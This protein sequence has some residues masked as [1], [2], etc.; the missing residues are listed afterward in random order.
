MSDR[1]V[2]KDRPNPISRSVREVISRKIAHSPLERR[3]PQVVSDNCRQSISL[4]PSQ[5]SFRLNHIRLS[6]DTSLKPQSRQT[7]SFPRLQNPRFRSFDIFKTRLQAKISLFHFPAHL[8]AELV[9]STFGDR[10][11]SIP[12]FHPRV[13]RAAVKDTPSQIRPDRIAVR[14][15]PSH[16][17]VWVVGVCPSTL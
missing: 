3:K 2:K 7:Q 13:S 9:E 15:A 16:K 17:R 8:I 6:T 4:S 12:L 11:I 10:N 1:P 5:I 14:P